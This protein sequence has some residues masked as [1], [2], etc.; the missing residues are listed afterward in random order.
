MVGLF[1][2]VFQVY[3]L[4]PDTEIVPVCPAQTVADIGV[5]VGPFVTVIITGSR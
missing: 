1:E 3:V 5:K 4:A 2:P